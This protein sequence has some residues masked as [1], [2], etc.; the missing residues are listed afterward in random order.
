MFCALCSFSIHL[1]ISSSHGIVNVFSQW[2]IQ[3]IKGS[4]YLL[5]I[6][7]FFKMYIFFQIFKQ[8]YSNPGIIM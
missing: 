4:A 7:S 6:Y 1:K 8:G 3:E 2:S 5:C